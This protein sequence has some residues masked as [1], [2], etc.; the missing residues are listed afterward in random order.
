MA[1]PQILEGTWEEL[2]ARAEEFKGHKL[3]LIVL[4][5]AVGVS[6]MVSDETTLLQKINQGLP[7]ATWQRYHEL[8]AKRRAETPTP[9]EHAGLIA[10]S[11]QIEEAHARRMEYLVELARLRQISLEA[12][13]EQLG[14]KT[15]E[16]V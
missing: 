11:N 6:G 10:L 9:E 14:I 2:S 4:P 16:Y 3:R 5:Q 12:L 15:P 13:M 1:E 7:L 8:V